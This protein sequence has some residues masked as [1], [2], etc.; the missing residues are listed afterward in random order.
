M[1]FFVFGERGRKTVKKKTI[2]LILLLVVN[3]T[4]KKLS[5][6]GLW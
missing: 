3:K 5:G 1:A 2:N 6:T 4:S